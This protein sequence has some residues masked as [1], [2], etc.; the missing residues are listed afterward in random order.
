MNNIARLL[1]GIVLLTFTTVAVAQVN[2]N[3]ASVAV[4]ATVGEQV[5]VGVTGGPL[6]FGT[7]S[8]TANNNASN[9]VTVTANWVLGG[10]RT[11]LDLYGYFDSPVAMT[12]ASPNN[13][14]IP[15][16]ALKA[17]LD[18]GAPTP[19]AAATLP[20]GWNATAPAVHFA[21]YNVG[22]TYNNINSAGVSNTLSLILDLSGLSIRSDS[23]TG[24][25]HVRV[26]AN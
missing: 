9:T 25:L 26:Q 4:T 17:V 21:S 7:V 6:A 20:S 23:Y 19:F 12:A 2:S 22:S 3:T 5:V 15:T 16:S 10:A 13:D 18:G 24:T 11:T 14:A 1:C 8:P